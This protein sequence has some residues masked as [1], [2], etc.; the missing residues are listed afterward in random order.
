M[1]YRGEV[2]PVKI[3]GQEPLQVLM[4]YPNQ[5]GIMDDCRTVQKV[6]VVII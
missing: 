2:P 3:P 6:E 1:D 5:Q 4:V